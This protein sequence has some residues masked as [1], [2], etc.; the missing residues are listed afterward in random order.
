MRVFPYLHL[1]LNETFELTS[2]VLIFKKKEDGEKNQTLLFLQNASWN[3]LVASSL[4][5]TLF[6]VLQ[7]VRSLWA[8]PFYSFSFLFISALP[9]LPTV[10]IWNHRSI[11]FF[12]KETLLLFVSWVENEGKAQ[13]EKREAN[14]RHTH[15]HIKNNK[16]KKTQAASLKQNCRFEMSQILFSVSSGHQGVRSVF[17]CLFPLLTFSTERQRRFKLVHIGHLSS[18]DSKHLQVF[19]WR[20]RETHL[21]PLEIYSNR[22]V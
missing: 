13:N 7:C 3:Y 20:V 21:L 2:R 11:F 9:A 16:K 5:L 17:P 22:R 18:S 19:A 10:L 15:T 14:T 8:F 12:K 6:F 4:G 1:F